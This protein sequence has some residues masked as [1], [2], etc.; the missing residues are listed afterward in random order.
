MKA[1]NRY[2]I[3]IFKLREGQH[4]YN[5]E[6]GK[7]FFEQFENTPVTEGKGVIRVSLDKQDRMIVVN[8]AVDVNLPLECDKTLK[9]FDHQV[10]E[11]REVLYKFGEQEE[12]LDDDMFVITRNTQ[13]IDLTQLIYEY[14]C[15]AIPMRKVH[16][17]HPDETE[18]DEVI[19][20][21]LEKEEDTGSDGDDDAIDP[22]W[23]KLKDLN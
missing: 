5:F 3:D 23:S 16:P 13:R 20:S 19:Y 7:A 8:V 22:R 1:D 11:T 10:T 2:E 14:I 6:V 4:T 15:T 21:S 12:E 17:D 18:Q 9:P